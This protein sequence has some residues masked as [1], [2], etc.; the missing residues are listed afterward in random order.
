MHHVFLQRATTEGCEEQSFLDGRSNDVR[1][2]RVKAPYVVRQRSTLEKVRGASAWLLKNAA[3]LVYLSPALLIIK[4]ILKFIDDA[5][6]DLAI[7]AFVL[8]V[9]LFFAAL[10]LYIVVS[11]LWWLFGRSPEPF[12]LKRPFDTDGREA[13]PVLPSRDHAD[14]GDAP[15]PA[16]RLVRTRGSI[17]RLGPNREGDGTV[18]RDLWAEGLRLTECIDFAIV[19]RGRIPVVLRLESAPIVLAEPEPIQLNSYVSQASTET[20]RLVRQACDAEA[21]RPVECALLTLREGDEVE[22]TG[23]VTGNIDNVDHFELEGTYA[24][25]PQPAPQGEGGAS[26]FRDKPGGPGLI[27]ADG[28]IV[29]R[30]VAREP[31]LAH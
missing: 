31:A 15:L 14:V 29:L 26:P 30:K 20:A 13:L 2:R 7:V 3:R 11:I 16:G 25:V 21:D 12:A 5:V 19:A 24:S 27:I 8:I 18:V 1:T 22:V 4:V 17:I 10:N 9:V 6:G 28:M 23:S